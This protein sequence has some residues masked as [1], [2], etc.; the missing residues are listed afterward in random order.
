M[1]REGLDEASRDELVDLVLASHARVEEVEQQLRWFKNQLF[2]TK[3]ERRIVQA[4]P[5]QLSLGEGIAER[6]E[7]EPEPTT[8]VRGHVRRNQN[9]KKVNEEPGLRFDDTV[10]METVVIEDPETRDLSKDEFKVIAEKKTYRLAQRPASYVIIEIIR[11][12]SKRKADGQISCPAAAESA[13]P[14]SYADVSLLAG[15]IV[16]KIRYYLPLY[17]QHQ[18]IAAAGITVSRYSLTNWIHNGIDLLKPIYLA[19]LNSILNS[20]VLAMDETP[21]R[22]GRKSKGKMRTAYFWPLFGDQNEVAFPYASTRSKREAEE[23]LG[24]YRGT[25]LTDGYSAY[26]G[27]AETRD[28]VVH[29]LCW[30]HAR[31]GFVKAEDVEPARSTRA[32]EMIGE[33]YEIER[34]IGKKKLEGLAKQKKRASL[35]QPIVAEFFEWLKQEMA[36]SALLPTN[37]FTKAAHYALD[38]KKG[39]EVFLSNPDVAIDT[40]HL[41]RALR[42]IPMGRKNWMFCWTEIGAEKIGWAQS[43]LSTCVLHD[44]DPYIYLV[45]VLQRIDSHPFERVEELT[46]RLWKQHFG[47]DPMRS[48]LDQS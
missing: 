15:M 34:A 22:A 23:I 37:P 35:S 6:A 47:D 17:R 46:P 36:E 43:L 29:A 3:S 39:L 41:E 8:P 12:V 48:I 7:T 30:A 38:R 16:D 5:S 28:K 10:P 26:K 40:N 2:G 13:L 25:L 45:D 18:R 21:I 4:D 14:G 42:P 32:L 27:F 44:V 19:Q 1:N 24:A 31:R 20:S 9:E 33:L 11:R